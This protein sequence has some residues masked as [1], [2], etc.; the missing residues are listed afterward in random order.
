[1]ARKRKASERDF[2]R[3]E[4][5]LRKRHEQDESIR[6]IIDKIKKNDGMSIDANAEFGLPTVDLNI[7]STKYFAR[8]LVDLRS[9]ITLKVCKKKEYG[10]KNQ[11]DR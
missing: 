1:M 4:E 8:L 2:E 3:L 9:K 5:L 7:N 10:K 6:Q 11:R